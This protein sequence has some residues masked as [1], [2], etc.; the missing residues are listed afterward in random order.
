MTVEFLQTFQRIL[1]L[2]RRSH[3]KISKEKN[4]GDSRKYFGRTGSAHLRSATDSQP[5]LVDALVPGGIISAGS[6]STIR[7]PLWTTLA[8]KT[9][10]YVSALTITAAHAPSG[11]TPPHALQF[12]ICNRNP[13]N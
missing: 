12:P 3:R 8:R 9:P 6:M 2:E 13:P 1:N 11:W 7:P 10:Q 4:Q 5:L